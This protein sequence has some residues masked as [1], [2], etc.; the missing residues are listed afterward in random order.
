[1]VSGSVLNKYMSDD[2]TTIVQFP[3]FSNSLKFPYC[4]MHL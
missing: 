4:E 1:M 2:N 3:V